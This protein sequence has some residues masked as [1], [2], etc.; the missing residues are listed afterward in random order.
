M[1]ST[2]LPARRGTKAQIAKWLDVSERTIQDYIGRLEL[3]SDKSKR[4]AVLPFYQERARREAVDPRLQT[5][6]EG[7]EPVIRTWADVEKRE[8][9][10]KLRLEIQSLTNELVQIEEVRST[11]SAHCDAVKSALSN[12]VEM[13]AASKR[14]PQ[15]L[16]WA[17]SARDAALRTIQEKLKETNA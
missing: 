7:D 17:E 6:A 11:L 13:I 8:R 1:S 3:K 2:E 12:W 15:V 5:V 14:D 16:E 4:Y 9:V 10:K